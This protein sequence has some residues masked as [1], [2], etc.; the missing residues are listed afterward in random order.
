MDRAEIAAMGGAVEADFFVDAQIGYEFG[1][2][3]TGPLV[4]P[5]QYEEPTAISP[6][7]PKCTPP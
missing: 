6:N 1:D 3:L 4:M 7:I 5:A 2:K